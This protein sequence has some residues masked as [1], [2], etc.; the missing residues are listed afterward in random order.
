MSGLLSAGYGV[1]LIPVI[2]L[3][4]L[5]VV[6]Y[7]VRGY[8]HKNESARM[9]NALTAYEI[10]NYIKQAKLREQEAWSSAITI[11]GDDRELRTVHMN[12]SLSP[13]VEANAPLSDMQKAFFSFWKIPPNKI[14]VTQEDANRFIE[15]YKAKL[16]NEGYTHRVRRWGRLEVMMGR[17]CSEYNVPALNQKSIDSGI[18]SPILDLLVGQVVSLLE[19]QRLRWKD[20]ANEDA[21]QVAVSHLAQNYPQLQISRT[22]K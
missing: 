22:R 6:L 17:F 21:Y 20:I 18:K 8:F 4:V 14:P 5:A 16:R 3:I 11:M 2:I 9:D 1:F 15:A 10:A 19:K 12:T 13:K 7:V